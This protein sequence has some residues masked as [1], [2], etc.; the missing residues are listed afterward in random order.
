MLKKADLHIHS[1]YSDKPSEWLLR[2][3]GAPESYTQP[4]FLYE[5]TKR[6]GMDFVTI[7][8]HDTINGALEIAHH[9]DAFI[10]VE[11]TTWFP[12][13]GCAIHV[14]CYGITE[15]Q[16]ADIEHLREN[17]YDLL[18]YLRQEKIVHSCAHPLYNVA[19][20]LTIETFEKCLLL[21]DVLEVANGQSNAI[22][23]KLIRDV[24]R[25]LTPEVYD[26]ILADHTGLPIAPAGWQK[27]YTG[28]SDDHSGLFI[29]RGYTFVKDAETVP[30]FL[31]G[32][33]EKHSD[34]TCIPETSVSFAHGLY[35]TIFSYYRNKYFVGKGSSGGFGNAMNVVGGFVGSEEASISFRDKMTFVI[36]RLRGKKS[37]QDFKQYLMSNLTH[38]NEEW[39]KDENILDP[40]KNRQLNAK[41]F[42]VANRVTNELLFRFTR[43]AINKISEGSIFGSIQS[44]SSIVPVGIGMVPYLI[45]FLNYNKSREFFRTVS[46]KYL[47][48][49]LDFYSN[50]KKAWVTDTF[51]DVNGVAVVIR[52][53]VEAG[54]KH[55]H[56]LVIVTCTNEEIQDHGLPLK[57]FTPVGDFKL[58]QNDSFTIAFPPFLE[59]VQYFEKEGFTEV[60]IS[61]PGSVGLAAL[62]AAKLLNLKITM[63]YH[64]DFPGYVRYYTDDKAMEEVAWKYMTWFYDQADLVYVPSSHY[65]NQLV[66]K[67]ID[68]TKMF[69]FPHGT[70]LESFSPTKRVK[71]AFD[72][73]GLN[74][75]KKVIYVGRVAKE[76]DLDLLP[77]VWK[78][79]HKA[80]PSASLVIV[81]DGPYLKELKSELKDTNTVFTGFMGGENLYKSFASA[82]VFLFPSTTDTFGNVVLESLASGV[83]AIVSNIGGPKD[84]VQDGI[85]G[86]VTHA[87]NTDELAT[88]LIELL[89]DDARRKEMSK[90]ARTYAES[91]SWEQIYLNFWN[92]K[93]VGS[94]STS[95]GTVGSR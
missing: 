32:I 42:E 45:S 72:S 28:G 60:I 53:M 87:K 24:T 26:R 78:K 47:R 33:A 62:W 63:I 54:L 88:A 13:D 52:K 95:S 43:K 55:K 64:T 51:T 68:P 37:Q 69:L 5:S 18:G 20:K 71:H 12:E 38:L 84:I 10:S 92:H 90:A 83:P 58:P 74:G 30:D 80:V 1:K 73:F 94:P 34:A 59:M 14:P 77:E 44:L 82:D 4:A 70:D 46:K 8:D 17:V 7:T 48:K 93:V 57:N 36:N 65:R 16:F 76:K 25:A 22:E 9:P 67:G 31:L 75:G 2:Q 23:N 3:I 56:Q 50:P 49:D 86:I 15:K 41:T 61:T 39:G 81:G 6:R 85:T 21:F 91:Q 79:V 29:A 11:A 40:Q 35:Y 66:R 27:G 89:T 19:G